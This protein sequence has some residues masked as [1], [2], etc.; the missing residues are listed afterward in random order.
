MLKVNPRYEYLS[1]L[2]AGNGKLYVADP[3]SYVSQTSTAPPENSVIRIYST[4][5]LGAGQQSSFPAPRARGLAID[6]DGDIWVL[7]QADSSHP[8]RIVR[9]TPTGRPTGQIVSGVADPSAI[10]VDTAGGGVGR[11][12]VTDDGP[13]QNIKIFSGLDG[14][15]KLSGTFGVK[16]GVNAGPVPG[17]VGPRRF[18]GPNAISVDAKG[19]IYVANDGLPSFA[20]GNYGGGTSLESYSPNGNCSGR[21]TR[22]GTA[23]PGASTRALAWMSTPRSTITGSNLNK[24]PAING[25]GSAGPKPVQIPQRPS[26]QVSGSDASAEPDGACR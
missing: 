20:V 2:A 11:L 25:H 7:E 15:P 19:N 26:D 3:N 5:N 16:G 12:F 9:Y 24:P 18:N 23:R 10:A 4:A 6:G 22:R 17:T 1:A 13:D 8:A 21:T 14:S